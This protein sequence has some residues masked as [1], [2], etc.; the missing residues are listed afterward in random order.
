LFQCIKQRLQ[1]CLNPLFLVVQERQFSILELTIRRLCNRESTTSTQYPVACPP[2]TLLWNFVFFFLYKNWH[3]FGHF[4]FV[5]EPSCKKS[6]LPSQETGN[7]R[8]SFKDTWGPGACRSPQL[9]IWP[10]VNCPSPLKNHVTF[11]LLHTYL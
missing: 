3:Y 11:Q 8:G 10:L 9:S 1:C 6:P 2:T 7:F 5:I 4:K